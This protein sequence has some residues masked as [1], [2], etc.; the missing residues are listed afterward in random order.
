MGKNS[1]EPIIMKKTI[2]ASD[3]SISLAFVPVVSPEAYDELNDY[4][5][6]S[7]K[8][9]AVFNSA[10]ASQVSELLPNDTLIFFCTI[11]LYTFES[12][13]LSHEKFDSIKII[14]YICESYVER[15][16]VHHFVDANIEISDGFSA[17]VLTEHTGIKEVEVN[18]MLQMCLFKTMLEKGDIEHLAGT[19]NLMFAIRP[20]KAVMVKSG[21]V[22]DSY[23]CTTEFSTNVNG[24][25]A[26]ALKTL[27][28]TLK[29]AKA[30][31]IPKEL[32]LDLAK[33]FKG[34][35]IVLNNLVSPKEV[36][37]A[38]DAFSNIAGLDGDTSTEEF[39]YVANEIQQERYV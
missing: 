2:K 32:K 15:A 18:P 4:I 1:K 9:V 6:S 37:S 8:Y 17:I 14:R 24:W 36:T 25:S 20:S 35:S 22:Y 29:N 28:S 13:K 12:I 26:G 10:F 38:I 31:S 23:Q 3:S 30:Q 11:E 33:H 16:I 39:R 19:S 21:D 34:N 5:K 27:F 7:D